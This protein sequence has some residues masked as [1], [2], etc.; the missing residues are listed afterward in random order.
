M[1][2]VLIF[3][4]LIFL[5]LFMAEEAFVSGALTASVQQGS[6]EVQLTAFRGDP[7][8]EDAFQKM[9]ADLRARIEKNIL[10]KVLPAVSVWAKNFSNQKISLKNF[11]PSESL[12]QKSG[13]TS[14]VYS[15]TISSQD[16][17]LENDAG[18]KL[19]DVLWVHELVQK[20]GGLK[21]GVWFERLPPSQALDAL[22]KDLNALQF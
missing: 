11:E 16:P 5:S 20:P 8:N 14:S 17:R 6:I 3:G 1:K 19:R 13:L 22:K 2:Q 7:A 18:R 12:G 4:S 21:V 15:S 10:P 9:H